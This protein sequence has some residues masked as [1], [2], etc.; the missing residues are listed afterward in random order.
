MSEGGANGL[1]TLGV[2]PEKYR[3]PHPKIDLVVILLVRKVLLRAFEMICE[4]G[5]SLAKRKE[6]EVTAALRAIVENDLRQSGSVNGFNR[7][8]FETVARQGQVVNYDLTKLSKTPDLCFKL[9]NDEE[10]PRFAL[11]E[12]DALFAECKPVDKTHA[13]G[14]NIATTGCADL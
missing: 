13:A 7:R 11:S 3:L 6:D 14:A 9:R 10:E 4:R 2:P 5:F 12:H 1:F 8:T